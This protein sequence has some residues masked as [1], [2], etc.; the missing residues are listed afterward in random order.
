MITQNNKIWAQLLMLVSVFLIF[1]GLMLAIVSP[2]VLPDIVELFYSL[3]ANKE[4]ATL[5]EI[6]KKLVL[7]TFGLTGAL[8]TGWGVTVLVV[9]YQL[10]K[11]SNDIL[12]L[13]I[14][15]GLISWFVLDSI[16]SVLMGAIFNVG[17]NLIFLILFLIPIMGNY[18]TKTETSR[19]LS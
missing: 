7:W 18:F 13:A 10:T 11:E 3:F 16:V 4:F 6:D 12:W 14:D 19:S 5:S 17:F 8:T 2:L 1:F 15:L 9:G